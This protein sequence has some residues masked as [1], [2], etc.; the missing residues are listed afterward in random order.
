M[1]NKD[2]KM[3]IKYAVEL[4]INSLRTFNG[5][6]GGDIL[7]FTSNSPDVIKSIRTFCYKL[8][9]STNIKRNNNEYEIFCEFGI[10]RFSIDD[11]DDLIYELKEDN[12]V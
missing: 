2:M 10:D 3:L 7:A 12:H 5:Y 4:D 1:Y 11:T 6:K 8:E 9:I